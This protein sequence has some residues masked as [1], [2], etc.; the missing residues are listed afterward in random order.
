MT[1]NK[2]KINKSILIFF[3]FVYQ[4]LLLYSRC[5]LYPWAGIL[6]FHST[7]LV[8]IPHRLNFGKVSDTAFPTTKTCISGRVQEKIGFIQVWVYLDIFLETMKCSKNK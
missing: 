7:Q 3:K 5:Y 2:H 6:M 8:A 4:C 1:I